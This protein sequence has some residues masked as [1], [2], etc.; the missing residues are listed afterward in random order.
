MNMKH[1]S[2]KHP[3]F[4]DEELPFG[5]SEHTGMSPLEK[6]KEGLL[7]EKAQNNE[8]LQKQGTLSKD[9]YLRLMAE[10]DNYKRRTAHEYERIIE[11]A[12]E[13]LIK[14]II[15]VRE[16]FESA[17]KS[18]STSEIFFEG[19]KLN[20]AKL[21]ALLKKNGLEMYGDVGQK[22]DP[23][24]HDALMYIPHQTLSEGDIVEVL[25]HG[26]TLKGKIIQHAR[27][28]VSSGKPLETYVN[29]QR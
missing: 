23:Q 26:Y 14:D 4:L 2:D 1:S 18:K 27:V 20:A 29:L 10:F 7:G 16:N 28:V 12:N 19:M 8:S 21:N 11:T 9:K 6:S 22:F 17:F 25:G 15:E 5:L 13:L 24:L 3:E